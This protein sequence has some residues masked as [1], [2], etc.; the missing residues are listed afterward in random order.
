MKLYAVMCTEQH[1]PTHLVIATSE[2]ELKEKLDIMYNI[3][4]NSLIELIETKSVSISY[5]AFSGRKNNVT[6]FIDST[7]LK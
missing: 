3:S 7:D 1:Q 4:D 6:L 5:N 2:K